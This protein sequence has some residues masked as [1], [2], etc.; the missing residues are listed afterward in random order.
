MKHAAHAWA[1]HL[2]MQGVASKTCARFTSEFLELPPF[3]QQLKKARLQR[4]P[5]DE[6]LHKP[7]MSNTVSLGIRDD[8]RVWAALMPAPKCRA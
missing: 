7:L 4:A 8:D 2:N 1:F 3:Q 5:F 6:E